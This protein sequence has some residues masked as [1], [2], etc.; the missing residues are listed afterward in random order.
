MQHLLFAGLSFDPAIR[1]ILVVT[2]AVAILGGSVYLIVAT[3]T[4][5]RLGLLITLGSLFGFLS[6][7]TGYWWIQPPGIGPRG[8]DPTW[9]PVEIVVHEPQNAQGPARTEVVNMLP[10]PSDPRIPSAAEV[11]AAH[12][13]IAKDIV[14]K[15]ENASLTDIAA[16]KHGDEFTGADILKQYFGLK[17][18]QP[19]EK[20][21][22]DVLGGW[23]IVTTS[24]AGE[25]AAAADAALIESK[26]FKDATEYKRV[27]AFEW[28]EEQ[29]RQEACPAAEG[30]AGH[31]IL[32]PDFLCRAKYRVAK[33]FRLFHPPRYQV[34][35]V[36]PVIPQ[37]TKE[38]EPPP[39]PKADPSKPVVSIVLIRDQG[40]VRA[41][42][43]Y[44]FAISFS[45]FIVFALILHYRDK[46]LMQNLADAEVAKAEAK[47]KKK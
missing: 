13:E 29:T 6:I 5:A 28:N 30:E 47:K 35:Q 34:I 7:L 8:Q 43:A 12:P 16:I 25:A 11:I 2:I 31:N 36:Q 22:D 44:F 42:P 10:E 3:N 40:N 18:T 37:E 17:S 38:G 27:G 4:G 23:E 45:L 32:P 14:G 20:Q 19:S 1:G 41:K 15:P 33:T 21:G 39:V 26:L 9:K 24:Q 46:T